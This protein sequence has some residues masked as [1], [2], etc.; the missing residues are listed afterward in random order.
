MQPFLEIKDLSFGYD[1]GGPLVFEHLDLDL[2]KGEFLIIKGASGSGKSTLLRLICRLNT[3]RSGSV[4]FK[5]RNTTDIPPPEL[6][7]KITY[8][9]QIP[10]MIDGTVRDNLLLSFTFAEGRNK[11]AP[12]DAT[13]E[14]MLDAFYLHGISLDQSAL[15]LSVGQKQRLS[16]MRAILTG[17][18]MLLLDEPTS[19]LDAESA[20]MIFSIIE[21]LNTEE[22][23]SLVIV[24]HSDYS[25]AVPKIRTCIF[26]NGTLE[27]A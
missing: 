9:P 7:S 20:A 4:R 3:P 8:V 10:Q 15:K 27:C 5:G 12:D 11:T 22:G 2:R 17:P 16:I 25:P 24:T 1:K 13:L 18:D 26:R 19:A 6:R 14:R 21:R 23:K